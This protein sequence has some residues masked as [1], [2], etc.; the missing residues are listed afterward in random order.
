M[1]VSHSEG[2]FLREKGLHSEFIAGFSYSPSPSKK[3]KEQKAEDK[4]EKVL[5]K[6]HQ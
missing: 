1:C 3:R 2:P 5:L 4:D 6:G